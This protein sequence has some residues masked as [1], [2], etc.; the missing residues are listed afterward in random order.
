MIPFHWDE[1]KNQK[2]VWQNAFFYF[3]NQI[4]MRWMVKLYT[5]HGSSFL[6]VRMMELVMFTW[7]ELGVLLVLYYLLEAKHLKS[8]ADHLYAEHWIISK[9]SRW[10]AVNSL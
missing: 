2:T 3:D 9:V 7:L 4:H 10:S 5:Y 6:Y 8:Q 1:W